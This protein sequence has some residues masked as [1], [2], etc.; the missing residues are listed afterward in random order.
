MTKKLEWSEGKFLARR[1]SLVLKAGLALILFPC[2]ALANTY[3]VNHAEDLSDVN[4][5]NGIC[6][7]VITTC[8]LRAALQEANAGSGP[9]TITFS[10]AF[11]DAEALC[12]YAT[13]CVLTASNVTIDASNQ[14]DTAHNRPG[15]ALR[16]LV[17]DYALIVSG[18][19][20]IIMGIQFEGGGGGVRIYG[21]SNN[22]IGDTSAGGRNVFLTGQYGVKT[23]SGTGG[24]G[25][26]NFVVGNYFGTAD[27]E[28]ATMPPQPWSMAVNLGSGNNTVRNNLIVNHIYG[29][30]VDGS[31]NVVRENIIGLSW[32]KAQALPNTYGVFLAGGQWNQVGPGNFIAGNTGEGVYVWSSVNGSI[33][34]NNIGYYNLGNGTGVYV[35]DAQNLTVTGNTISANA[36]HGIHVGLLLSGGSVNIQGNWIG[37]FGIDARNNKDGIYFG[38][39]ARGTIGGA[40]PGEGNFIGRNGDHGILL[41]GSSSVTV[42]GNYIGLDATSSF[43]I[44]NAHHGLGLYNGAGGNWIV[45][46]TILDSGWSGLA[47]VGSGGN[48]VL[49]NKI[50]TDGGGRNWGNAFHGVHI[51]GGAGNYIGA[52]RIAY[53]GAGTGGLGVRIEGS[54]ASG[55]VLDANS[56]HDNGAGPGSGIRLDGGANS[57]IQAPVITSGTCG[58][59]SGI[60]ANCPHCSIQIFSDSADQG[61]VYQGQIAADGNGNFSWTQSVSGPFVTATVTD[62]F[63]NTSIFSG[64][65]RAGSCLFLPLIRSN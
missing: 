42:S 16:S 51:N 17:G 6:E 5:G 54:A 35:R 36:N 64:P 57:G 1:Q 34:D 46:N 7:T 56:I 3:V 60:A 33:R 52:N 8:S 15:V 28:T 38:E 65:Y 27:G 32:N 59:I 37:G 50:G 14:W 41:D 19:N 49:N 39:A 40:N 48:F 25:S 30:R 58:P 2:L 21:G 29:V 12:G 11:Q 26:I 13:P 62:S 55:N 31:D 22:T 24:N 4:P 45:G 18:S 43:P 53:N 20:N 10:K 23:E 44:G 47:I 61:R 9:A 63:F